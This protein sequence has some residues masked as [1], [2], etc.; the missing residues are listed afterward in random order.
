MR[1]TTLFGRWPTAGVLV[2]AA[3][4]LL[5]LASLGQLALT[6]NTESRYGDIAWQM[7]RSGDWIIPWTHAKSESAPLGNRP[8]P[9]VGGEYPWARTPRATWC[10]SEENPRCSSG[11]RRFSYRALGVSEFSAR[12]PSFLVA[13]LTV[14]ATVC[15]AAGIWG[16]RVAVLSGIILGTSV[17]MF[18]LAGACELDV[19]LAAST[20]LA[21]IAFALF[22]R[23]SGRPRKAW[24][25]AFFLALAVGMLAKGPVALVLVGLTVGL[26]IM[27][28]RR[29]RLA[30]ELPWIAGPRAVF[31]RGRPL[32][33]A[34]RAGHARLPL[35]LPGQR[36]SS[37]ATWS[38]TTAIATAT[39]GC[40]PTGPS[41]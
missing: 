21:M 25:L 6:D 12:L 7:A 41:G 1:R 29:W 20:T 16:R 3:V 40:G 32:V 27:L 26:W 30:I 4:A 35:V 22:V 2:L 37:S 36:E 28:T 31:G 17:E 13:I 38:I 15:F 14:A 8:D 9:T 33:S 34:G 18:V 39:G 24:G 10:P 23:R 11:W 5:R 19:P